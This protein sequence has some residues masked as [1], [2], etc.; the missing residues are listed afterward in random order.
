MHKIKQADDCYFQVVNRR[1]L[2]TQLACHLQTIN[3]MRGGEGGHQ[4]DVHVSIRR[5]LPYV[6]QTVA[7]FDFPGK[8]HYSA[9]HVRVRWK[10]AM[11]TLR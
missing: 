8:L 10:Y 5:K 3:P 1:V 7:N 2:S 9:P 4:H 6:F 11:K